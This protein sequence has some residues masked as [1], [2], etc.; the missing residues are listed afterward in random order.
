MICTSHMPYS[1]NHMLMA[2]QQNPKMQI[3]WYNIYR[4]NTCVACKVM[5]L[6]P[7]GCNSTKKKK[8][9]KKDTMGQK[10]G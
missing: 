6:D 2:N 9:K 3:R 5:I 8:K 7:Q 1:W 10:D 4:E